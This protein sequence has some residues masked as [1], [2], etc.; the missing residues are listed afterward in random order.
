MINNIWQSKT[1]MHES[2]TQVLH[3]EH[4]ECSDNIMLSTRLQRPISSCAE[5]TQEKEENKTKRWNIFEWADKKRTKTG[6][7]KQER[8]HSGRH[9][10]IKSP[11]CGILIVMC[12]WHETNLSTHN[13]LS[14]ADRHGKTSREEWGELKSDVTRGGG[15]QE[16][17]WEEMAGRKS[18]RGRKIMWHQFGHDTQAVSQILIIQMP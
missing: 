12:R 14:V 4:R 9:F 5:N 3:K 10:K 13:G 11:N 1:T 8:A 15:R 6:S 18:H 16:C 17:Q 7:A 2:K